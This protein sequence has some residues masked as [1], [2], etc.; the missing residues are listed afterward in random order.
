VCQDRQLGAHPVQ[1][2]GIEIGDDHA[3]SGLVPLGHDLAPGIDDHRVAV[4]SRHPRWQPSV[5][6]SGDDVDL[7]LHGPGP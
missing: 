3:G 2:G 4:A 1:P 6:A 5:L 7:V